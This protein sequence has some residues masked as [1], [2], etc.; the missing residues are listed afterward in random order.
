MADEITV[1]SVPPDAEGH[2]ERF[3][4]KRDRATGRWTVI[5]EIPLELYNY[6]PRSKNSPFQEVAPPCPLCGAPTRRLVNDEG[7]LFWA[8]VLHVKTGCQGIVDYQDYLDYASPAA[9][10]G[11]FLP[12]VY[13][14]LFWKS[15]PPV[16]QVPQ[17]PHPLRGRWFSLVQEAA[18][19]LGG[20]KQVVQWLY[21]P[22]RAFDNK[23]PIE[24]LGTEAGCDA[25]VALLRDVWK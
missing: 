19:V 15:G 22:K 18:S 4:A 16:K 5:G 8:C 13:G 20:D 25:V 1:L 3:G 10:I 11:D 14:S 7:R 17:T 2:A 6:L 23:P 12:N 21:Q 9:R 24:M